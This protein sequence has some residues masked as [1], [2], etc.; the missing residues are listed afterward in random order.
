MVDV[1][2]AWPAIR[3]TAIG[4][5]WRLYRPRLGTWSLTMLAA[6]VA[7]SLGHG[8]AWLFTAAV[9]AGMMGG[10]FR[11]GMPLLGSLLGMMIAGFFAGGMVRMAVRQIRG[12][13][14]HVRR[15]FPR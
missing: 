3:F 1:E 14:P 15:P 12:R 9:S 4:E 13:R 8:V 2:T 7:T 5:A 6:I 11:P 10:L